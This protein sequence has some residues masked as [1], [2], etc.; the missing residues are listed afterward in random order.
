MSSNKSATDRIKK[1]ITLDAPR[2]RVWSA[3]TDVEQFNTWFGVRLTSAF[4]PGA[5]VSGRITTP[6]Y[7]HLTFQIWIDKV[8]PE[9]YFSFHW[10]PHAIDPN[11]DYSADPKT[12]VS[13][14]LEDVGDKTRLTI[15]E[16]GF[17]AIPASR[18][19]VAFSE[20]SGGWAIQA[21]N[22]QKYLAT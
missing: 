16:D 3:I 5:T 10:H 20:N 17:D 21:E 22:L 4:E 7:D 6:G 18:R 8:E 2:S 1:E 9:H 19:A 12:L 15:V 11:V 14:T 13:F